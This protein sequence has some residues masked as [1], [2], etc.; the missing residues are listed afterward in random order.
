MSEKKGTDWRA[1]RKSTHLASVDLDLMKAD[2]KDLVF[3]IKEVKR[4]KNVDVSGTRMDG[5]FCYFNEPIKPMKVNNTNLEIMAKLLKKRGTHKDEEVNYIENYAGLVVELFVD[6]KVKFMGDLVDGIRIR[7]VE[8]KV[9]K[10]TLT[11]AH[12][13]FAAAKAAVAAGKLA[14]VQAQFE[15]SE[16]TLKLLQAK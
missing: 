11:P 16:A 7:P 4:E 2:G 15:I 5:F 6:K 9:G 3:T 1:F 12:P 10:Q 14:A 8:P 13:R